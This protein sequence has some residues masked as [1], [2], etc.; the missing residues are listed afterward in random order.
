MTNKQKPHLPDTDN[1]PNFCD[2]NLQNTG[3]DECNKSTREIEKERESEK[4]STNFVRKVVTASTT[5]G[6]GG[7]TGGAHMNA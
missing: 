7:T 5:A 3:D 6:D 4:R 1:I 2:T